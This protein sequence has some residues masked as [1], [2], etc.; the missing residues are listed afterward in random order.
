M[1]FRGRR[2]IRCIL[3]TLAR[4]A[5]KVPLRREKEGEKKEMSRALPKIAALLVP[6]CPLSLFPSNY[7]SPTRS[8][9]QKSSRCQDHKSRNGLHLC[10]FN[11]PNIRKAIF[12]DL[13]L[14]WWYKKKEEGRGRGWL[15]F[16]VFLCQGSSRG[17]GGFFFVYPGSI[18]AWVILKMFTPSVKRISCKF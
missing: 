2:L 15:C 17:W 5:I 11:T 9:T 3:N 4:L 14:V 8:R 16:S 1:T 18:T 12:K 6:A 13:R 7:V 10:L